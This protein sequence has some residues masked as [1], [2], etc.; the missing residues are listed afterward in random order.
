[1][2]LLIVLFLSA[3]GLA[4]FLMIVSLHD[5]D[6]E[7]R[8]WSHD[9]RRDRNA[10]IIIIINMNKSVQWLYMC[11][12]VCMLLLIQVVEMMNTDLL[13]QQ[14]KWKDSLNEIRHIMTNLIQQVKEMKYRKRLQLVYMLVIIVVTHTVCFCSVNLFLCAHP[15]LDWIAGSRFWNNPDAKPKLSKYWSLN[16]C[17]SGINVISYMYIIFAF[18]LL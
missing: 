4:Y 15:A 3:D 18:N 7:H 6:I 14:Q 5:H 10:I 8:L 12:H 16:D 13:R 2:K 17:S 11:C 1:V 9:Q